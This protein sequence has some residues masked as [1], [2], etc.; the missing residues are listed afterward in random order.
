LAVRCI[1]QKSCRSSIWGSKVKA[2]DHPGQKRQK[3]GAFSRVVL[4]GASC[5]V[6]QFYAGGKI[7]ACCLVLAMQPTYRSSVATVDSSPPITNEPQHLTECCETNIMFR[8]ANTL[9]TKFETQRFE[10]ESNKLI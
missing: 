1:V 9:K 4:G 7:S 5:V 8:S 2:Q 3:C 6:C 10:N